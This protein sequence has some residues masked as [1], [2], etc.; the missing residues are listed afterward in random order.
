MH[1][2]KFADHAT[3]SIHT[4]RLCECVQSVLLNLNALIVCKWPINWYFEL[5]GIDCVQV[6]NWYFELECIGRS[7]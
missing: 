1:G 6:A 3:G 4:I 5:E 7:G 2:W